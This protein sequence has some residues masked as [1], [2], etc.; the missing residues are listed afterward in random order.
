MTLFRAEWSR[1]AGYAALLAF[2]HLCGLIFLSRMVDLGQQNLAVHWSFGATYALV[3][4]LLGF[5]QFTAYA[6]PSAWL[7]LIH[8]PLPPRDIAAALLG[9][10]LLLLVIAVAM[11]IALTALWQK[12]LTA[13]VLD[14][15]H[16]LLALAGWQIA[17]CAYFGGAFAALAPRRQALIGLVLLFWLINAQATGL[18]ALAVQF[19]AMTWAAW[20]VAAVFKAD[21]D[22]AP[23]RVHLPAI[24][25][26]LAMGIYFVALITFAVIELGWI[27][28][29]THPNNGVPP[30]GGHNEMEKA[31]AQTRMVAALSVSTSGEATLL[32]EQ[33]KLS[34][35]V[36]LGSALPRLPQT[37]EL[38]NVM[39]MEFDDERRGVRLVYS[40]T[41]GRL[42][43]YRL[44]DGVQDATVPTQ[45]SHPALAFGR[46]PGM[47]E[48]DAILVS[49][50]QVYQYESDTQTLQ[51][52]VRLP[53]TEAL[54]GLAP[55]GEAYAVLS[56]TAL[57]VFD[58][59]PFIANHDVVAPR[60]RLPLAGRLGDLSNLDLIELVDGHL[61]VATY[62][63]QA[64]KAAG[65][66]PFQTAQILR[67]DGSSE[68]IAHRALTRDFGWLYRYQSMWL[69]PG[70]YII[71]EQARDFLAPENPMEA[72]SP[73]PPPLAVTVLATLLVLVAIALGF[74]LSAS[75]R[76]LPRA[77]WL[78]SCA[79][80]GLPML[81]A[82]WLMD[83][84]R[85]AIRQ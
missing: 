8:R 34:Q 13:R 20:M 64:H 58:A 47:H 62:G 11:P 2:A 78:A 43:G 85:E 14:L 28:W 72:T 5:A 79:V 16:W 71:R 46:L 67:S 74:R 35:P 6:R 52:R 77:G 56:D 40:H 41:D 38:A 23:N 76:A 7:V 82:L 75:R 36:T 19:I 48:G 1:L 31:T 33:V 63:G 81:L 22:S 45:F 84:R 39:P 60:A 44:R 70:L 32:A 80:F 66:A 53:G 17:A 24:A 55:L 65:V 42:R 18:A 15:R 37:H 49:R 57:Y 51:L 50:G 27:A 59:R 10:G 4:A 83:L 61:V 30:P 54:L 26:P 21:R 68:T 73:E 9:A 69:S 29:G 25:L 12:L 3:G